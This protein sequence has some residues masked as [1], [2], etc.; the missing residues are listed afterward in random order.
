[1]SLSKENQVLCVSRARVVNIEFTFEGDSPEGMTKKRL[2]KAGALSVHPDSEPEVMEAALEAFR[3]RHTI[4][5]YE[6]SRGRIV[7]IQPTENL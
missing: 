1:M 5:V 4:E 6:D 7:K 2:R 3:K